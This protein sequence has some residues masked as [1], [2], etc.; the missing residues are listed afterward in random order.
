MGSSLKKQKPKKM[1]KLIDQIPLT[2]QNYI[3]PLNK[4]SNLS[5]LSKSHSKPS[6]K[7]SKE[8]YQYKFV[9]RTKSTKITL[10]NTPE[11]LFPLSIFK[12][13]IPDSCF[14]TISNQNC[15]LKKRNT[16]SRNDS[17]G[18]WIRNSLKKK[19]QKLKNLKK[20]KGTKLF[21]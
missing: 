12:D 15:F 5:N 2:P 6:R 21:F 8:N 16:I 3:S 18:E 10:G 4:I 17:P 9:D 19:E 20:I 1:N 11:N 13:S 14:K 7:F